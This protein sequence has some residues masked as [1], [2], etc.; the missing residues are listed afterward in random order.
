MPLT[1]N[2]AVIQCRPQGS[3]PSPR[4]RGS[5]LGG[6]A[7]HL[8]C[9]KVA[10]KILIRGSA[11]HQWGPRQ[12]AL[13]APGR[14]SCRERMDALLAPGGRGHAGSVGLQVGPAQLVEQECLR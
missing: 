10:L 9:R 12:A 8:N 2:N 14:D 4:V 7:T 6:A 1:S 13:L 11:G 3:A 5:T